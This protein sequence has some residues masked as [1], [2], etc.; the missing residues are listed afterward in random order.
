MLVLGGS[1]MSFAS[2][3][4][5]QRFA[6]RTAAVLSAL[7]VVTMLAPPPGASAPL[8][9]A[10]GSG[11]PTI[12]SPVYSASV[13]SGFTGPLTVGFSNAPTGTYLATLDC[14]TTHQT[15]KFRYDG[16]LNVQ[17][18]RFTALRGPVTC[19]AAVDN[20]AGNSAASMFR[21]A[22]PPLV[23]DNT[24]IGPWPFYPIV[25][26]G[27]RDY[28][29]FSY[30]INRTANIMVQVVTAHGSVIRRVQLGTQYPGQH[31]WLW[32]GR[33]NDGSATPA[34]TYKEQ[35]YATANRTVSTTRYVQVATALRSR[36]VSRWTMGS[37]TS[38][39]S[40]GTGCYVDYDSYSENVMLDCWGGTYAQANYGFGVP[41]SAYHVSWYVNGTS[42]CCDSGVTSRSGY[43]ARSTAYVVTVKVTDWHAYTIDYVKLSYSYTYRI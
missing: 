22:A 11:M 31:H 24:S 8:G 3:F 41:S 19:N 40:R 2:G 38:S 29:T 27:Y 17:Q 12:A 36:A 42:G 15:H 21:V 39:T 34:A 28:A 20:N 10:V 18:W 37:N 1:T 6:G 9:N 16:S 14:G 4:S 33:K 23:L 26:D 43:R 32:N 5:R 30:R 25:H 7:T 13:A 35:I